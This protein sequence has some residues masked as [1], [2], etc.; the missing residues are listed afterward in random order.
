MQSAEKILSEYEY[1]VLMYH[2]RGYRTA[3]IAKRLLRPAKSVD[4]AKARIF[5]RLRDAF[6]DITD[7]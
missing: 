6:G 4:N 3:D 1:S 7:F 5:K 2:I